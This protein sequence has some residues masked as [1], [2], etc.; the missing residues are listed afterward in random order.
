MFGGSDW[1]NYGRDGVKE[2]F[3]LELGNS[4]WVIDAGEVSIS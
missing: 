4:F 3:N 1:R 2:L